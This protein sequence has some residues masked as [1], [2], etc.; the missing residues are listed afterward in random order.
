MPGDH[1]SSQQRAAQIERVLSF[2]LLVRLDDGQLGLIRERE[3]GWDVSVHQKGW[4]EFYKPGDTLRVLV[5]KKTDAEHLELSLRLAQHDPWSG[6]TG[7]YRIGQLVSG[8]VTTIQPYGVF[9]ELE[10]G[11]TGLLHHTQLPSWVKGDLMDLFWPHDLVWVVIDSIETGRRRIGL[12]LSKALTYRWSAR[13]DSIFQSP[14]LAQPN[15]HAAKANV[16]VRLPLELSLQKAQPHSILI[17]DDDTAQ[18]KAMANWLRRSGQYVLTA[19]D[20]ETGLGLLESEHP[21]WVL[22]DLELPGMNGIEAIK[23]IRAREPAIRCAIMT[24]WAHADEYLNDLESLHAQGVPLLIKPILP[25][26]LLNLFLENS[27]EQSSGGEIKI[28]AEEPSQALDKLVAL[29]ITKALDHSMESLRQ[30]TSASKVVLFALDPNQR[31]VSVIAQ[32][33]D[34]KLDIESAPEL[35]HSPVRDVAEDRMV[36]LVE[37]TQTT[38]A[39]FRKLSPLLTFRSCLGIPIPGDLS[40]KYALFLFHPNASVFGK[41]NIAYARAFTVSIGAL[42]ERQQF[43][44]H[45]AEMQ[46]LALLGHLTRALVHEINHQLGPAGLTLEDLEDEWG[47]IERMSERPTDDIQYEIQRAREKLRELGV[48]IRSLIKTAKL[49]RQ[50]TLQSQDQILRLDEVVNEVLALVRDQ[51]HRAHVTLTLE[52]PVKLIVTRSQ[53]AQIQQM[54]L[55]IILN[56]VQQIAL[57]RPVEGGNVRIW[58]GQHVREGATTLQIGVEDDGP[59]IHRNLW[60][61]IFEL[62]FTTRR[63]E[64]TGVGL[65]I[66]QGLAESLGGRVYVAASHVMWGSTFIVELPFRI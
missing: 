49:F 21:D 65:Y 6:L 18:N 57:W 7:R 24:G 9:V 52:P 25:E 55:N 60:E 53:A 31:K 62:G 64:G 51:A 5:L 30:I 41:A 10:P 17:V 33:G 11:V 63:K 46:R 56:A 59:G 27:E 15:V 54:L 23:R 61:Q 20:A 39:R 38:A 13:S 45:A 58:L 37:D 12:S 14:L 42:L 16:P 44:T 47:R 35:I 28:Y 66:S 3:I 43:Q 50:I 34:S 1:K 4:R 40:L 19:T 2:G 32:C 29:P 26:D 8:V 36:V 48:S 22:M